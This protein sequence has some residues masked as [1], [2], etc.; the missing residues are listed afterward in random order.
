MELSQI[1]SF[2]KVAELQHITRAADALSVTQP[3]LTKT[4]RRMEQELEV[5]LLHHVGR[6]IE[7]SQY[8]EIVY[9]YSRIAVNALDDMQNEINELKNIKEHKLTVAMN[10]IISVV[11]YVV[12]DFI[13]SRPDIQVDIIRGENRAYDINIFSSDS[14]NEE[15]MRLMEEKCMICMSEK[16][17]LAA[18]E[19]LSV[20]DVEQEEFIVTGLKRAM[21]VILDNFCRENGFVPNVKIECDSVEGLLAMIEANVGISL[22]PMKT[23][24]FVKFP[25][26]AFRE[27]Q[28]KQISRYMYAKV[29]EGSYE[30]YAIREFMDYLKKNFD[31][32]L[33]QK[34]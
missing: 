4:I 16:N 12:C 7:L 31:A 30:T 33:S 34:V 17:P 21:Y 1:R 20:S 10:G 5:P 6:N 32:V 3:T 11:P 28:G 9:K 23:W 25:G 18:K 15:G 27:V 29:R 26:L 2:K 22:V 8:G 24:N 13:K 14:A 19:M